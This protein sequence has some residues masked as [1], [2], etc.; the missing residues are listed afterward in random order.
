MKKKAVPKDSVIKKRIRITGS[1]IKKGT[2]G[3]SHS[4]P[5]ALACE[6]QFKT[7][8]GFNVNDSLV[9][10]ECRSTGDSYE[11]DMPAKGSRFVNRFDEEKTVKPFDLTLTFKKSEGSE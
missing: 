2:V 9:G 1:D 4:C 3:D 8:T 6:R 5:I 11:A 7:L 10:A